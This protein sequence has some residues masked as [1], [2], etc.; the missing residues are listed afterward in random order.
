ME[1]RL[2]AIL[3]ADVVGYSRL[4]GLDESGT[5]SALK[6][7]RS[8]VAD[9]KIAEHQGRIV[10]L[11]GDGM[12][13]EFPSV[14]NAVTCAAEIQRRMCE[15]NVD[16]PEER[17]IEFR[18]G[19]H[20]GDVIF[21]DNDIFGD[22]VNVAARIESV[23]KPGGVAV[24]GAVRDSVANRLDL[25]FEDT[26]EQM[27][28]NIDRPVR[29][30]D[31]ILF[32]DPYSPRT[33]QG[34][35]SPKALANEGASIA[36][37]PFNNMSGDPEQEYFSD[38]ITEDIITDLSRIAGLM[39]VARNSSFAYK[40]KSPD[41]RVVGR[42]LGVASVLEGSVR[43]AGD[44]IRITAQLI[45]TATGGHRWAERFD[46]DLT[47]I[48]E[49]QDEVTRR[50]V[51]ALKIKLQ[52]AEE[53]HLSGSRA[54]NIQ[55]HD[56]FLRGRELLL[57][58]KKDREVFDQI[59]A[60]LR[61]AIEL[62]PGFAQ[63]YAGLS[64]AHCLDFQNHWTGAL[65]A[66]DVASHFA[67]EAVEK[68]P[69]DPYAHYTMAVVET[70][71]RNLARAKAETEKALVLNPNYALA[72]GTR[73]LV[74]VYLGQPIAGVPYIERAIR[75]DPIFTQQYT[76]FL[77][78]A[79]LVAEQYEAAASAFRERIRLAP[80]TDLSR[81]FLASSLGHLGKIDEARGVWHELMMI[82]PRYSLADHLGRL[83]FQNQADL[84]RI[85]TG[86]LLAGLPD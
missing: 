6:A 25:A 7:H 10:K 41:I 4:M 13:A 18:I 63:P 47:D 71:K 32:A 21:E 85:S 19:V 62:D 59:V 8:E 28:K 78:S 40:N 69:N 35:S 43:R 53:T 68:G 77:G 82:N 74:D 81:A 60:T 16:T 76:H 1:R 11:T 83:P 30:F 24:S 2:T 9:R 42:E 50:I 44:R 5:L 73:G 15:R 70:W 58:S 66:L 57:G 17:R 23:A 38:G 37:L 56:L 80:K 33:A 79:Y 27:L 34:R 12:L 51:D 55:A 64:M 46:R 75:L 86:L 20:L 31:L 72:Y 61:R 14:V 39:V 67:T 45:D 22:G 54:S 52:P 3:A 26:G 49:L 84:D 29:I 36:V 65:D 48:F